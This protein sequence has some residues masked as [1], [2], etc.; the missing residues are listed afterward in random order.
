MTAVL[1]MRPRVGEVWIRPG[2]LTQILP[3]ATPLPSIDPYEYCYNYYT[4]TS[5]TVA[6]FEHLF[7]FCPR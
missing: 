4:A 1:E 2:A 5:P 3:R 6:P 7:L